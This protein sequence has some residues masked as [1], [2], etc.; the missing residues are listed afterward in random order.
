MSTGYGANYADTISNDNLNEIVKDNV[1]ILMATLEKEDS[2]LDEFGQDVE[3]ECDNV[4]YELFKKAEKIYHK[5][6]KE[7]HKNTGLEVYLGFH[8]VYDNGDCYDDVD[9]V[10]WYVEGMY[11]LSLKG[12]KI[13]SIVSRSMFVT[14][15]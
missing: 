4:E 11:Q 9:G 6:Q 7:F 12:K 2:S 3:Q 13:S 14:Y 10:F 1:T 15:G 5:I 8:S